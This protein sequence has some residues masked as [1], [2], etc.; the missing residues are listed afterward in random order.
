MQAEYTEE[1]TSIALKGM[2]S[3]KASSPDGFESIF[4][5]KTWER[6]GP[7]VFAF[8]NGVFKGEEIPME[9][10]EALLVL[11]P[12]EENPASIRSFRPISLCNVC[13]YGFNPISLCNVCI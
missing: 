11:I 13:F 9:A 4:F 7:A 10:T 12:K 2:G 8:V 1:E 3:L 5:K 6:I